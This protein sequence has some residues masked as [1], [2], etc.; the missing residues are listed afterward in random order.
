[1][2]DTS[3]PAIAEGAL[4]VT[5]KGPLAT[6]VLNR[7]KARNALNQAMWRAIPDVV[8]R[9]A[10]DRSVRVLMLRGAGGDFASGADIA[11]FGEVFASP[12]SADAYLGLMEAAGAA[13]EALDRPVIAVIEGY[14]IGAG[15]A[16]A[17]A[18][19]L[20]IAAAD[21]RLGA[22]PAKLGLV[23]GPEDVRR[24]VE[25]VGA[26]AAKSML[27][28]GALAPAGAALAM[29]LVTEVHEGDAAAAAERRALEIAALS[30]W[31]LRR[32]KA[33]INLLASKDLE[34]AASG[35]LWFAEAA[36]Q[37]DLAEGLSALSERRAPRFRDEEA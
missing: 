17:L 29:G 25:A 12:K 30:P 28:T 9:L 4:L 13:L 21:A 36:S 37:G 24:L 31:S 35:R 22:P 6:L 2:G 18:C 10:A 15:L 27:L 8:E 26:P 34:A 16:L 7:P 14:C 23:Y 11:E 19:D 1:M 33:M 32:T 20:R 5:I 3:P